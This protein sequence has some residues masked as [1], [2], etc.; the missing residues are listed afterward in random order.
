MLKKKLA[1]REREREIV[2][3]V[4]QF[5]GE[6]AKGSVSVSERKW[7]VSCCLFV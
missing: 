4:G 2:G 6:G 3:K 5:D 1:E 7:A